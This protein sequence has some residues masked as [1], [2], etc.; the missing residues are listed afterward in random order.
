MHQSRLEGS[1]QTEDATA[2]GVMPEQTAANHSLVPEM[3]FTNAFS[4]EA[5]G[6]V[7]GVPSCRAAG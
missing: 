1:G 2:T 4:Q 6:A 5:D 7:A 3:S